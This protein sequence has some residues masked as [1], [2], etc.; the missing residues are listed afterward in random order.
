[1]KKVEV[2]EERRKKEIRYISSISRKTV[3]I[4][5]PIPTK[6]GSIDGYWLI[7]PQKREGYTVK[8][9]EVGEEEIKKLFG[10]EIVVGRKRYQKPKPHVP[11]PPAHI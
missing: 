1:M 2:I 10:E 3:A 9:L 11:I 7:L 6:T 8:S 5:Q 4:L